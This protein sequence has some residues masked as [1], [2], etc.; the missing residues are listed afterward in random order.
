MAEDESKPLRSV[1]QLEVE[2][3]EQRI[4]QTMRWSSSDGR[5]T[6]GS[7]CSAFLLS[8]WEPESRQALRI[9]LWTR[10]MQKDEMNLLMFQT[11]LTLSETYGRAVGD[12]EITD[13]IRD[14]SYRFGEKTQLI[15]KAAPGEAPAQGPASDDGLPPLPIPGQGPA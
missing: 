1:I 7:G 8:I 11:L 13:M 3:D 15:R 2:L 12:R 4:P 5:E 10:D 6:E 9:D 14:F